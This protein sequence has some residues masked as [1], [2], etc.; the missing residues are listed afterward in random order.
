[1]KNLKQLKLFL[2]MIMV[3]VQLGKKEAGII[4][5]GVDLFLEECKSLISP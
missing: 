2:K 3:Y 4:I 1:M 5:E